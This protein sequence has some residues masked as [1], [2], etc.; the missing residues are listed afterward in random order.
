MGKKT[1]RGSNNSNR[2]SWEHPR[3]MEVQNSLQRHYVNC[4]EESSITV[5]TGYPGTGKT[6]I[7]ARI[8]AGMFKRGEI[9]NI[10]LIRPN[11]SSS[12]SMGYY[13]GTKNEKMSQWLAPV[14]GALKEEFTSYA[15]NTMMTPENN[16]LTMCPLELIKGLSLNDSFIIVDEAEDLTMAE[17]KSVLTRI[18]TNSKIV[19]CGDI[20][21]CA[22]AH[23]GLCAL[24]R[25]RE[26][27]KRLQDL[28]GFVDFNDV[29]GIVR[30]VACKEVILA[31]ERAG[32]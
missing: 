17:I 21:Q 4:I 25:L 3:Q 15:L 30:S 13:P 1:D 16:N 24:L 22:L 8:A 6:Y 31:F 29:N 7:P 23:S 27:D 10:T 5:A 12:K 11:I 9:S 28:I 20:Q 26:Q 2:G 18:G 14:L 19:L 32:I